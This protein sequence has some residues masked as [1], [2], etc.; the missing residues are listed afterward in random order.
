MRQNDTLRRAG[1]NRASPRPFPH[2]R[3]NTLTENGFLCR[4]GLL[5]RD[6]QDTG[7]NPQHGDPD[8]NKFTP[9][10]AS[11]MLA[12]G[13]STVAVAQ[14]APQGGTPAA[15]RSA[16][17]SSDFS[18]ADVKKFASVQ[19]TI[20]SIREEYSKRLLDVNDPEKAAKLQTEAVQRMVDTVN[21]AGL[22]VE[23]YNGIAIALQSDADLRMRVESAMR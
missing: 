5:A 15:T 8:M 9:L 2:S 22:E 23:T 14:S 19:P 13:V 12:L 10:L 18:D 6:S 3:P 16:P 20:E 4:N 17:K 7:G 21:E 1:S 11:L